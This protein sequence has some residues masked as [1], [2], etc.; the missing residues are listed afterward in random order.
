MDEMRL[1]QALLRVPLFED[2][3]ID[4]ANRLLEACAFREVQE[5]T[6]LCE[7]ETVDDQ[8][9]I[10]VDGEL[11]LESADGAKLADVRPPGVLGEMGV[12]TSRARSSRVVCPGAASLLALGR[13][14]LEDLVAADPE[15]GYVLLT[16]LLG[17][18]YDRIHEMNHDTEGL[19]RQIGEL[20][21]HLRAASP[22]D[23]LL[24]AEEE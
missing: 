10:L 5:E 21:E 22:G 7:P 1:T 23:P 14:A 17:L 3:S 15:L 4:Q 11:R 12:F 19:R 9:L 16:K 8:L 24:K 2:L 13:E 20:R 6:V 18:L